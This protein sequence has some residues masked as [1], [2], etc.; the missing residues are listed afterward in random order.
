MKPKAPSV[1]KDLT[2]VKKSS[3]AKEKGDKG[4]KLASASSVSSGKKMIPLPASSKKNGGKVNLLAEKKV[5]QLNFKEYAK[6]MCRL[7]R[8]S[9]RSYLLPL[10]LKMRKRKRTRETRKRTTLLKMIVL[11]R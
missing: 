10:R 5:S 2:T 11:S 9:L 3:I 7:F 1:K 4:I 6:L 8:R